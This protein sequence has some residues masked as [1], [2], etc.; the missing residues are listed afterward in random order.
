MRSRLRVAVP[1]PPFCFED[2]AMEVRSHRLPLPRNHEQ[3]ESLLLQLVR[4]PLLQELRLGLHGIEIRRGVEEDEVV[5][6][7]SLEELA[8]GVTPPDPDIAFML[9]Q[10]TLVEVDPDPKRHPLT[11]LIVLMEMVRT[12]GYN[13]VDWYVCDGDSLDSFVCNPKGT[14]PKFLFGLPVHYVSDA[15]LP[16][17]RL[18]LVGSPTRFSI[19]AAYSVTAE[20]GA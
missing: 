11:T 7:E 17:G 6:P 4:M 2:Y 13:A 15:V 20:I 5:V 8:K 12:A 3:L 18:V 10:L 1:F 14:K 16:E 19:D 9:G